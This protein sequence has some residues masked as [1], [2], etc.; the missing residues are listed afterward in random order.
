MLRSEVL[1]LKEFTDE[2]VRKPVLIRYTVIV[3]INHKMPYDEEA[4]GFIA[5]IKSLPDDLQYVELQY[6]ITDTKITHLQR[7]HIIIKVN[8]ELYYEIRI[9]DDF[10]LFFLFVRLFNNYES[11]VE[12]YEQVVTQGVLGKALQ[13]YNY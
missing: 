12:S 9:D 7:Q 5:A 4:L 8:H 3:D 1:K 6:G 10:E 13:K 2:E 11:F